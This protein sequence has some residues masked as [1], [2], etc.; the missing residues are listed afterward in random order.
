[1]FFL[2]PVV[3]EFN[4][5]SDE[6]IKC[7]IQGEERTI[8]PYVICCCVD[9]VARAPMQEIQAHNGHNSC[10]WCLHPGTYSKVF[11]AMK[12]PA[13]NYKNRTHEGALQDVKLLKKK[14]KGNV[15]L[16]SLRRKKKKI[17][18]NGFVTRTPLFDLKHF[19]IING[20]VPD[21]LHN[22]LLG[23]CRQF[24]FYWFKWD[25]PVIRIQKQDIQ[26]IDKMLLEICPPSAIDR[27]PR[28]IEERKFWKAKEWQNYLLYFSTPLIKGLMNERYVKHWVLLVESVY[29]LLQEKITLDDRFV[30]VRMN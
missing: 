23:I 5:L 2:Q 14:I 26:K 7:N 11:K 24:D 1:M 12:F 13:Y 6:V 16:K 30:P 17:H 19:D 21:Y 15:F 10:S 8:S 22:C 4:N 25:N 20:F 27:L 9:T 3:A 18:V 29:T 28:S